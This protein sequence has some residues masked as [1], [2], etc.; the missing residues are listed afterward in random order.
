[1]NNATKRTTSVIIGIILSSGL[2]MVPAQAANT[3]GPSL[4][5]PSHDIA[6][7]TYTIQVTHDIS[8]PYNNCQ[9]D[10]K[11]VNTCLISLAQNPWEPQR[12][13]NETITETIQINVQ[14]P[15]TDPY[16]LLWLWLCQSSRLN[17]GIGRHCTRH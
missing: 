4:I 11:G 12:T 5:L 9:P 3:P 7:G 6:P 13:R 2:Q 1:M 16:R 8:T 15:N 14:L 17:Q 10:A